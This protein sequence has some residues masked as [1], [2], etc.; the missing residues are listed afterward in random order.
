MSWFQ[1]ISANVNFML[2][3]AHVVE[4]QGS[5]THHIHTKFEAY[6]SV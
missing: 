2:I 3:E 1:V 4:D 5:Q 6:D